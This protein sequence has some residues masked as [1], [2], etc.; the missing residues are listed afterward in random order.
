LAFQ[1]AITRRLR[2]D[3][4]HAGQLAEI[5]DPLVAELTAML[6]GAGVPE[7]AMTIHRAVDMRYHGQGYEIEVPLRE[8]PRESMVA[9]LPR[10]AAKLC[11]EIF[12]LSHIDEPLG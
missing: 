8:N 11:R 9:D 6:A 12:S 2:H 3:A 1:T 7:H 4:L 10:R 5:L